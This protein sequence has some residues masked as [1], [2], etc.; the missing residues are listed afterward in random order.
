MS[1]N[2][3][4]SKGWKRIQ[5]GWVGDDLQAAV[6]VSFIGTAARYQMFYYLTFTTL[7]INVWAKRRQALNFIAKVCKRM[8]Q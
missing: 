6:S 3:H 4:N 2:K 5:L 8:A 7:Y 1:S